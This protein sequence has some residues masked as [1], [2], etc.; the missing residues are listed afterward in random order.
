MKKRKISKLIHFDTYHCEFQ[1]IAKSLES[2]KALSTYDHDDYFWLGIQPKSLQD[3]LEAKLKTKSYW[4][5]ITSPPS[6]DKVIKV[7]L[8]HLNH[9]AY[10]PH[11]VSLQSKLSKGQKKKS[12][13]LDETG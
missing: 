6:I 8:I 1:V 7:A 5:D 2:H 11:D 13:S 10:Q 12:S 3:V 9:D 4:K